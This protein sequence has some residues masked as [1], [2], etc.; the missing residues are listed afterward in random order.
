GA[1]NG[2]FTAGEVYTIDKTQPTV[3]INQAVGQTDPVTGPTA[4][5]IINFTAI[6][7]EPVTGF[8][9]SGVTISGTANATVANVTEIAPND[10]THFNVGIE[11][12]TQSGTVIADIP[13]GAAHDSAGNNNT[14][15]TFTDHTVTFFVDNFTT[16]EVNSTADADDGQCAP[17][18]TGN[19]NKD[20]TLRE[21]IN[22]ANADAGAETIT[23][24]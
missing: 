12:M 6:F 3:T 8:T 16:F 17:A 21:A 13:A 18:G 7:S 5:T 20:C 9:A 4:S 10:G 14:I 15:G 19:G 23:F 22:A 24:N 11:G 2:N 1:G